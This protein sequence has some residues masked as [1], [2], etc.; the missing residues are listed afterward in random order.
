MQFFTPNTSTMTRINFNQSNQNPYIPIYHF[1]T[2][3]K[4]KKIKKSKFTKEEDEKLCSLVKKYGQNEW[5]VISKQMKNRNPRQ[6]RERWKNYLDPQINK[7]KWSNEEDSLLICKFN[8]IGPYWKKISLFFEKRSPNSVR[9]RFIKIA[10]KNLINNQFNSNLLKNQFNFN[11]Y[12]TF[13]EH[14]INKKVTVKYSDEN[15]KNSSNNNDD[16]FLLDILKSSNGQSNDACNSFW[17]DG[18]NDDIDFISSI[19]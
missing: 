7:E 2:Y 14:L 6:V 16:N 19:D 1:R 3:S 5:A 13:S 12:Q 15:K 17:N 4:K 11:Q 10:H 18:D 8:E 9:N